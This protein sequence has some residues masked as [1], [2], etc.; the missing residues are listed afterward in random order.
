M[1]EDVLLLKVDVGGFEPAVIV[2]AEGLLKE[3]R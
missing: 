2:S 3:H 1:Q